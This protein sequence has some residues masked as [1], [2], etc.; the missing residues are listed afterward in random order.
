M[1]GQTNIVP[2]AFLVLVIQSPTGSKLREE[3][4]VLAQG[5]RIQPIMV[6]KY[7]PWGWKC[8]SETPPHVSTSEEEGRECWHVPGFLLPHPLLF[9]VDSWSI[10]RYCL[11]LPPEC[12]D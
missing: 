6:R 12:W 9:S 11:P 10:D 8:A 4:C 3:G 5:L 1:G 2:V 7:G